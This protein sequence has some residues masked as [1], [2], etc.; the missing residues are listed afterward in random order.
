MELWDED[1]ES[2]YHDSCPN[3]G[4]EWDEIDIEFQICHICDY[5]ANNKTFDIKVTSPLRKGFK[6]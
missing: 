6:V 2:F 4:T 3:C 1:S 5:D